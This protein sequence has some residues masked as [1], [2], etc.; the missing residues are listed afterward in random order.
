MR[1]EILLILMACGG[2]VSAATQP[3]LTLRYAR[4]FEREMAGETA[5][6]AGEYQ[7]LFAEARGQDMDLAEKSLYR[8][9]LS[10]KKAGRPE[11][12]RAAW[13]ALVESFPLGDTPV[14][15]ARDA[16][17]ALEWELDR[18]AVSGSVVGGEGKSLNVGRC[19]VFAGEWGSE[20]AVI[21]DKEGHF[22]VGRR[23]AGQLPDGQKYGL[24][25]AEHA[26]WVGVGA[27][28]WLGSMA[29]GLTVTLE[30]PL[31]IKGKVVDHF[32]TPVSGARVQITG[33]KPAP[34]EK[35]GAAVAGSRYTIPLPIDRLL[36][37]VFSDLSGGFMASGLPAGLRYELKSDNPEYHVVSYGEER[38]GDVEATSGAPWGHS[39]QQLS[40]LFTTITWL[41]GISEMGTL[42]SWNELKGHVVVFHFRS[43][44]G[45]ASLRAQYP[46]EAG[47]LTRLM[48]L[49]G[50]SGLL[51]VWVLPANEGRG[52]AARLALGLNPDLPVGTSAEDG[53]QRTE[54][55]GRKV[56]TGNIVMGRDG[57]ILAVCSD[58][59]LFKAVKRA[60]G[61]EKTSSP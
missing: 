44:Y 42:M 32:G 39:S 41:R 54:D 38:K 5:G 57:R 10:H 30:M 51:C 48:E 15:N 13:V 36:P 25:Y 58:Q 59:Q 61:G 53:G 21:A 43:A 46:E 37:P 49:Y 31:V 22:R 7:S 4:L 24:V 23:V 9:G 33:F 3:T 55:R 18:V 29:T 11:L 50:G 47:V 2:W 26:E 17:K 56:E 6:L 20:P 60:V 34:E 1:C 45:E 8:A 14:S 28:V 35:A 12:A 27:D 16:L 40:N 19:I 52:E